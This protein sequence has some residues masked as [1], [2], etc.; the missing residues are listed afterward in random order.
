MLFMLPFL[1][2]CQKLNLKVSDV[3]IEDRLLW[4]DAAVENRTSEVIA[5]YAH[6]INNNASHYYVVKSSNKGLDVH[7]NLVNSISPEII[8]I[9]PK[10]SIPF[11]LFFVI[12]KA[13]KGIYSCKLVPTDM[14]NI[15][16]ASFKVRINRTITEKQSSFRSKT[17]CSF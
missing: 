9:N 14:G 6:N 15:N 5:I 12:R 10:S 16:C 4:I 11:R 7:S 3:Y 2:Q 1:T 13:S 17:D 8:S